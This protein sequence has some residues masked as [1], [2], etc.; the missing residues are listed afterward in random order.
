MHKEL[1]KLDGKKIAL[2]GLGLENKS[3][4]SFLDKQDINVE[5]TICDK[6]NKRR[7]NLPKLNKIKVKYQLGT[8]F[9]KS[10][11]KFDL[12]LRSP[13]WP[14]FCLGVEEAIKSKKTKVSSPLNIF[15]ALCP[16]K[17]II[18]VTGTKGKGTTSSLIYQMIKDSGKKAFLGGNIG[19]A[20]IS[21]LEEIK[22]ED[23]IVLELSSF[24]LEDLQYSPHIS[25]ITNFY[26]EHLVPADPHNPNFHYSLETYWQA[27]LKIGKE[28]KKDDYLIANKK[29]KEKIEKEELK[30]N[31]MYFSTSNLESKLTGDFNRENIAATIEVV[32]ILKISPKIYKE[33]IANFSNLEHRLELVTKL[34]GVRYFNNSFSTTPESTILDLK[35]FSEPII[36]IAGGADKGA[37]FIELAEEIKKRVRFLVLLEGGGT[38]RIIQELTTIDFPKDKYKTTNKMSRAVKL[39]H[40]KSHPKDVVLLSTA[41]ASFGLFKNYKERGRLF[42]EHV[43]KIT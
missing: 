41:C 26:K 7:L 29:L 42:K 25:V 19:I 12:I 16:S 31:V 3:L 43:K 5:I 38:N 8:S 15:F 39:A 34:D 17:N 33:T 18:G 21:F 30:N 2:L 9:N 14:L 37:D 4:L 24:Q 27:K 36:L 35:S 40:A 10:L 20:P 11:D 6:R 23:Y 22:P 28:Q 13:G 1:K 32:K